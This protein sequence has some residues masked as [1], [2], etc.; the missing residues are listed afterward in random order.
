VDYFHARLQSANLTLEVADLQKLQSRVLLFE[1]E[2]IKLCDLFMLLTSK[3]QEKAKVGATMLL[4]LLLL[5]TEPEPTYFLQSIYPLIKLF[6]YRGRFSHQPTK[7]NEIIGFT[8]AI[9]K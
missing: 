7:H 4:L 8:S 3:M 6:K 5:L 1:S 9:N 2:K